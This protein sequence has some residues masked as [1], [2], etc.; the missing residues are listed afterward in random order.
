MVNDRVSLR[1]MLVSSLF[2]LSLSLFVCACVFLVFS[3]AASSIHVFL[4]FFVVLFF[5]FSCQRKIEEKFSP[6]LPRVA[7][8][9]CAYSCVWK[10][11]ETLKDKNNVPTE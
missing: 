9:H 11:P 8:L 3:P 1:R 7:Q 2:F 10:L 5:V 6:F 4:F